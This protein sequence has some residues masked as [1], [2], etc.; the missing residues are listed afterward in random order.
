[1]PA[2]ILNGEEIAKYRE[3][4]KTEEEI[5]QEQFSRIVGNLDELLD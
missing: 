5:F 2:E 4:V 1:M 3:W